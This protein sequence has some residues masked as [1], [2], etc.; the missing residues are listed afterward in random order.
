[1][2]KHYT[3]GDVLDVT[4]EKIVPRGLGLA[5]AENLTVLV[6]LASPGDE[7]RVAI[8]EIKKRTAF[9]DIV[10]VTRSGPRRVLPECELYGKCGGCDM[11]HMDYNAQLDAKKGF[12]R[13]CLQRIGK[14]EF[15]G[16]IDM[17][18]CPQPFEYRS[19]ARWHID[20]Q[21]KLLGYYARETHDVIDVTHCPILTPGLQSSLEYLR[22]STNWESIWSDKATIEAAS[23]EE[24]RVSIHSSEADEPAAELSFTVAGET[25]AF[26]AEV[27]F[28]ANKFLI[29]EL[30]D[31]AVGDAKG[32]T[33][34]DLYSGVGLFTLPLARRFT[35]VIAVEDNPESAILAKKNLVGAG[36]ENVKLI[37]KSVE[38]FLNENKKTKI[39][40]ILLDPPRAGTAK[41][42]IPAIANLKPAVISYVSCEPSILARDLRVFVDAGYKLES[43]IALDMFPQTHHVETVVRLRAET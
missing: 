37:S 17:I 8:R 33:A 41:S 10:S 43:I 32:D 3:K 34:V 38:H 11:Q 1:L 40:F 5:F 24:G 4:I 27:F 14:I 30:I 2:T 31:T 16:E 29:A 7:L 25:Y 12:V 19:R 42:V 9:A 26:S 28:Q 23:G 20:R 21:R 36:L 18:A 35:K 15:N 39:D 13:D 6:P 22:E